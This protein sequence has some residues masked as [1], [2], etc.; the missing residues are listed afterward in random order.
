MEYRDIPVELIER[1]PDQPRTAFPPESLT[2]LAE[3]IKAHG[4]IQAIEVEA[5][6][7]GRYRLHHGERRW[8]A[9][10][11]AGRETIPAIVAPARDDETALVRGLL[12]NLYREDLNPIDEA[13]VYKRLVD[14]GWGVMRIARE[15]GRAQA[16]IS[17][18]LAWLE[19]EPEIQ[20][21]V[22]AGHLPRS[23][24]LASAL[25]KLTPEV[26]VPLAEKMAAKALS[27][28]GC[29]TAA[30]R[31]AE[32]LAEQQKTKGARLR[33]PSHPVPM[34]R[35]GAPGI[36]A[37]ANGS[38]PKIGRGVRDAADA[39]CRQCHWR[40]KA[41]YTPSWEIVEAEAAA[42]CAECQKRDGPALPD[43]CRN[44]PGVK[45]LRALIQTEKVRS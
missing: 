6:P 36:P 21:L 22:A 37:H 39:M 33:E 3:S 40:P 1:N 8:R 15:T 18:R 14:M 35:H 29:V 19:M 44:C 26:R 28:K 20:K 38:A 30:E 2:E 25:R 23:E 13:Q 24:T 9:S 45:M 27:L 42:V 43:I 10:K 16:T 4:V 11:L 7:D 12:E 41:E 34:V 32:K 17:G 5:L 31:A